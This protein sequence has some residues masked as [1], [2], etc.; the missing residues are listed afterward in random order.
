MSRE[1]FLGV[2]EWAAH[3]RF[4]DV[5]KALTFQ[6]VE[7]GMAPPS[8]GDINERIFIAGL[9]DAVKLS[10]DTESYEAVLETLEANK[11]WIR[12]CL[13][14]REY[15]DLRLKILRQMVVDVLRNQLPSD[16]RVAPEDVA[17][18]DMD[19][20]F[21]LLDK[22]FPRDQR[23]RGRLA[24]PAPDSEEAEYWSFCLDKERKAL[25]DVMA[26]ESQKQSRADAKKVSYLLQQTLKDAFHAEVNSVSRKMEARLLGPPKQLL[27]VPREQE[28]VLLGSDGIEGDRS[29]LAPKR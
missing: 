19:P 26:S 23:A 13:S 14:E 3:H 18:L 8:G 1:E 17:K 21:I 15:F 6:M 25:L 2:V 24:S 5:V 29:I 9:E 4:N 7:A 27:F 11:D 10:G 28:S 12:R 22:Y 20:Y 16:A